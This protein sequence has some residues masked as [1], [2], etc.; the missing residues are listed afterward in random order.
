[1]ARITAESEVRTAQRERFEAMM[2]QDVASLDTLL[3]DDLTYVHTGGDLQSRREF[4][5]TIKKQELIYESIA[6]TQVRVRVYDGLALATGRSEM[7]VR[8]S[9]GLNSFTIRFTEVYVRRD[10]HWLLTAWQATRIAS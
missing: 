2:H 4:I 9:A 8:N 10:G 7:R 5:S 3:D 6:P 1:M